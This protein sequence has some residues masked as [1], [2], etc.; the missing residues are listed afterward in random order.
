[1]AQL[2]ADE[3]VPARVVTR[4][5]KLGHDVLTAFQDGR[6]NRSIDDEVVLARAASL[7]RCVLTNNR[8]HF[9][10]LHKTESEHGGIL[11]FTTDT[12][13][14]PL[15][16]RIHVAIEVDEPMTGKFVRVTRSKE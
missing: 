6:A 2:Y 15:A 14:E 11:T 12:D 3:N 16:A 13:T 5:R 9:H 7:G 8:R 4:L 10:K 1:M